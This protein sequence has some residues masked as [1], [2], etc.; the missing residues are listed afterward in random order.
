MPKKPMYARARQLLFQGLADAGWQLSGQLKVP[1]ATSPDGTVR[2]WFRPQ[3]V[4]LAVGDGRTAP[5]FGGARSMWIDI[6]AL[7]E[8]PGLAARLFERQVDRWVETLSR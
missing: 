4:Y 5:T 3:S 8:Q 6:R 7:G 1:H 2:V